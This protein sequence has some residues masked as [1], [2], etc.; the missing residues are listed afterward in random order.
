MHE[1]K[2]PDYEN[3]LKDD[4]DT[5]H[6]T[7]LES[8]YER[9]KGML[10]TGGACYAWIEGDTL[11]QPSIRRKV[12]REDHF[13]CVGRMAALCALQGDFEDGDLVVIGDEDPLAE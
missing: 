9:D 5:L 13:V 2:E 1:N 8:A 6:R 7:S 4:I 3:F 10:F 11:Q 12:A